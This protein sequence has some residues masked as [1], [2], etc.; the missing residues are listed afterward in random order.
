[1]SHL[2]RTQ[3]QAEHLGD[4]G[5]AIQQFVEKNRFSVVREYCGHGIGRVFHDVGPKQLEAMILAGRRATW[6]KIERIRN[7]TQISRTFDKCLQRMN[8]RYRYVKR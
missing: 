7:T 2:D 1:V 4:V 3:R 6:P 8:E 5:A